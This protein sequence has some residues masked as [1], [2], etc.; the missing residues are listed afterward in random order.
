MRKLLSIFLSFLLVCSSVVQAQYAPQVGVMGC[1]AVPS[2]SGSIGMWASSCTVERGYLNIDTPTLGK[3]DFGYESQGAGVADRAVVSLGDSG[4][5]TLTF[6]SMLRDG[7]GA[8]FAV[9]E[10]GFA[11][12]ANDSQAFLEL[13][14]VSVSSDGIRFFT[15]PVNS[16][17][18]TNIQVR[19]SGDFM[20]ANK[21]YNLAGKYI[22]DYGTPFDLSELAGTPG[23]DV[24]AVTHVRITDVVGSISSAHGTRD[25]VG[26]VVNDP[27]PTP[28]RYG[29]FDLDAVGVINYWHTAN[30]Q[31][32]ESMEWS[33]YPNPAI[34]RLFL[35]TD[36]TQEKHAYTIFS[37]DGVVALTGFVRTFQS[38]DIGLLGKGMYCMEVT[39][40]DG[41]KCIRKFVKY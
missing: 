5:A 37:P 6:P 20:Y 12:A 15:F 35:R 7:A 24:N 39:T 25:K 3:V 36:N 26:N 8:D 32:G 33:L 10:N 34:D 2:T 1:T 21:L 22:G 4:T 13:A 14:T 29:G 31:A 41:S 28:F 23:L 17:T 11:N 19:G 9:F 38:I 30:M 18:P 16:N 27:F 40:T